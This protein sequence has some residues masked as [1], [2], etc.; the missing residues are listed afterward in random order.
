MKCGYEHYE[1]L[2]ILPSRWLSLLQ[3]EKI[4]E[5]IYKILQDAYCTPLEFL[6]RKTLTFGIPKSTVLV[7]IFRVLFG[8]SHSKMWGKN[9][10]SICRDSKLH[11]K[12]GQDHLIMKRWTME[13]LRHLL[14]M[15]RHPNLRTFR[16]KYQCQIR[17]IYEDEMWSYYR[18]G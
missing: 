1:Q 2:Y 8:C 10:L 12:K 9:S 15:K 13:L 17:R 3:F 6:L 7:I 5:E 18:G 11:L 16:E 14:I 4:G